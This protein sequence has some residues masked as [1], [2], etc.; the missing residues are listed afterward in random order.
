ML[1]RILY[2]SRAADG[3]GMRDVFDI[4]RVSHNRNSSAGLTGG[5]VFLDGYFFQLL[6]GLEYA[7]SERYERIKQDPRHYDIELRMETN[8]ATPVFETDWM[9]LRDGALIDPDILIDHHYEV[10]MPSSS[11]DGEQLFAFMISC[12]S[13]ELA[14]ATN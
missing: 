5:L 12:F 2:S 14:E 4:I 10:G 7:V 13:E 9:A 1:K 6:E 8:V 11:F 3:I